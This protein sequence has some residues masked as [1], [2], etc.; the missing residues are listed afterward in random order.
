VNSYFNYRKNADEAL[1]KSKPDANGNEI[2]DGQSED[3]N[4]NMAA[5]GCLDAILKILN[6]DLPG[7]VYPNLVNRLL[8]VI[9]SAIIHN[10]E[11]DLDRC[12]T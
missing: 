12:I 10:K 9:N 11:D 3:G 5:Q 1:Q 6:S 2:D 8:P 7:D 4:S